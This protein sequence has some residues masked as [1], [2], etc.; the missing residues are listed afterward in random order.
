MAKCSMKGAKLMEERDEQVIELRKISVKDSLWMRM[1]FVDD[2]PG[3][4][5]KAIIAF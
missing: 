4:Q 2:F 1:K 5:T 3:M